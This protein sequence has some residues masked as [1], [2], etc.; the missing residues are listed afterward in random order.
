LPECT[1]DPGW[2][3]GRKVSIKWHSTVKG[4]A[5]RIRFE[6]GIALL[7]LA[8]FVLGVHTDIV[9][10]PLR[11]IPFPAGRQGQPLPGGGL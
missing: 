7:P 3:K 10:A 8:L 6:R 4:Q 9:A 2:G 11:G 5:E 1:Q